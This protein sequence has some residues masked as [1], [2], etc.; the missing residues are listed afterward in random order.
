MVTHLAVSKERNQKEGVDE[1]IFNK[2]PEILS[3]IVL[4]FGKRSKSR[5]LPLQFLQ[6]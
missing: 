2:P 6:N 1:I 4:I 5:V 3:V